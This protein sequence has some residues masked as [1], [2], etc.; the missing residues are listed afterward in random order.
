MKY[1]GSI[2]MKH[3]KKFLVFIIIIIVIGLFAWYLTPI[4]SNL[5]TSLCS[6]DGDKITVTFD[7]SWHR[8]IIKPTEL[9]GTITIDG[10]EYYSIHETNFEINNGSFIENLIKKISMKEIIGLHSDK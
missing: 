6:V 8:Y 1:D 2:K 4:K 3:N 5:A 10:I 9:W 7:V